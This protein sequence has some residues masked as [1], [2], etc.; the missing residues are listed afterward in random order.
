MRT[1]VIVLML[2][3]SW[4]LA[5]AGAPPV[6]KDGR[7]VEGVVHWFGGMAIIRFDG[8]VVMIKIKSMHDWEAFGLPNPEEKKAK[9]NGKVAAAA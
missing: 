8:Q 5:Q 7:P 3:S 2:A 9:V 6:D 1:L 4:S